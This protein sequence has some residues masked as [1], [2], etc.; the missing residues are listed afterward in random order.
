M[1][2]GAPG[3]GG[4]QCSRGLCTGPLPVTGPEMCEPAVGTALCSAGLLTCPSMFPSL[5]LAAPRSRPCWEFREFSP[6]DTGAS[7]TTREAERPEWG[8]DDTGDRGRSSA[9]SPQQSRPRR[10]LQGRARFLFPSSHKREFPTQGRA[11]LGLTSDTGSNPAG[12]STSHPPTPGLWAAPTLLCP[13]G[14]C[15]LGPHPCSQWRPRGPWGLSH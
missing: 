15:T 2:A 4:A 9:V 7:L 12:A 1:A 14:W 3:A 10:S 5:P 8:P 13:Q 11:T 6:R